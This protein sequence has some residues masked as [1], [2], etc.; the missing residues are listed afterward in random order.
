MPDGL[1]GLKAVCLGGAW[2]NPKHLRRAK[3]QR[4]TP[5]APNRKSPPRQQKQEHILPFCDKVTDSHNSSSGMGFPWPR[6][7]TGPNP[8]FCRTMLGATTRSS[9]QRGTKGPVQKNCQASAQAGRSLGGH[10]ILGPLHGSGGHLV[11][12]L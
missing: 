10:G 3:Q 9:L 11:V 12:A 1:L 6:T 8:Q 2:Y 4:N 5:E 7:E